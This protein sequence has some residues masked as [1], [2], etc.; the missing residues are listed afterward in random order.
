MDPHMLDTGA[1]A[2]IIGSTPDDLA[3]YDLALTHGS[4]GRADYQ[5][6]EFLGDRVLGLVI[7][8]ELYTRFPKATE[9]EMSSRLHVLAS[10]ATC[11]TIA[12]RLDL[13]ALIRFGAQARN[14]SEEHTSELQ[15]L[16]RISYAVFCLKKKK[17]NKCRFIHA[18]YKKTITQ[19][20]K[21]E[22]TIII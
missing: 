11:A 7:A 9:G 1:L 4:T 5:R 14:R 12:Q 16:M 3:L 19:T 2:G 6:L 13:T 8:S 22:S 10:G 15:S 17:N 21:T 18:F 20:T